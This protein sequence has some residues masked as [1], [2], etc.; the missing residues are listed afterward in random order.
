VN[1]Q[2]KLTAKH[3][4]INKMEEQMEATEELIA[5]LTEKS[6]LPDGNIN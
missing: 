1:K 5:T 3:Y 6:H 4:R 2:N